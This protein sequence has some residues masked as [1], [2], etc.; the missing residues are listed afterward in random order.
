V[1]VGVLLVCKKNV[2][3]VSFIGIAD[4]SF[5]AFSFSQVL[6]YG[7]YDDMELASELALRTKVTKQMQQHGAR[8]V[9]FIALVLSM[10]CI[11]FRRHESRSSPLRET[12]RLC[13]RS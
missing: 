9:V 12:K 1:V 11:C 3:G 2:A 7:K 6:L 4:A 10:I 5:S 13:F 8:S